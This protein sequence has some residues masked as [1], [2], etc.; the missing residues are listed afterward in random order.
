MVGRSLARALR[1]SEGGGGVLISEVY[2][3]LRD[4]KYLVFHSIYS[5]TDAQALGGPEK[6]IRAIQK[7]LKL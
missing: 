6:T 7:D 4:T 1:R 2:L 3:A 5:Q